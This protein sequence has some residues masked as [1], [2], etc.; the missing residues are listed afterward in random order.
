[1]VKN[2]WTTRL[3]KSGQGHRSMTMTIFIF[4]NDKFLNV[5]VLVSVF[6]NN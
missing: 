2:I 3:S 1:M 6:L 5:H 4:L